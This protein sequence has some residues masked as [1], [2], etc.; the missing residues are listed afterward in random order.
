[1]YFSGQGK[2]Y[3]A[4]RDALGNAGPFLHVGNVPELNL[5]LSTETVDHKESMSGNRVV[6]KIVTT[7]QSINVNITLDE[8][9]AKNFVKGVFGTEQAITGSTV[10]N[11]VV[12]TVE[13][14]DFVRLAHGKVSSVVFQAAAGT[15]VLGTHYEVTDANTG[16][17]KILSLAT[18]TQPFN[19]DYT[20]ASSKQVSMFTAPRKEYVLRFDGLNTAEANAPVSIELYK[21]SLNPMSSLALISDDIA[22]F[23][24]SGMA[25]YDSLKADGNIG[26]KFGFIDFLSTTA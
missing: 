1:M 13:V 12:P 19:V 15:P 2:V 11:E 17:L 10:S 26:G 20:Y 4:N 25:L 16:M 14:G 18:L 23:A 24:L 6:D 22:Q 3:L 5:E 21:V 9:N 8:F 7:M